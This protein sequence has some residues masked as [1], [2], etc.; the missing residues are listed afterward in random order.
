[1]SLSRYTYISWTWEEAKDSASPA[2][3]WERFKKHVAP[4]ANYRLARYQLQQLRRTNKE[5][6]DLFL[7]RC[8]NQTTKS[9]FRDKEES[10]EG[11]IEQLCW[12]QTQASIGKKGK[13]LTLD[14]AID[15]A[16]TYEAI[17]QQMEELEGKSSN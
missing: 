6:G 1:M 16:R 12:N 4:K 14:R 10:D 8:R 9:R 13:Q 11:L 7:T 17:Q 15:I 2:K 3:I 5:F